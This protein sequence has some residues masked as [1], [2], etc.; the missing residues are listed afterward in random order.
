MHLAQISTV[1]AFCGALIRQYG[2]LLEVPSDY[3]ML[4]DPRRE[5][6]LTRL[7]GDLLEEAYGEMQPGFRLLADTLGAGRT[8]QSLETLIRS[9]FERMLTVAVSPGV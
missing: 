2:Y 1:H 3:T 7:I 6:M 8:D 5:E 4:E 9:V